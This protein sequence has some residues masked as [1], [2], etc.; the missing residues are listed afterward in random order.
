MKLLTGAWIENSATQAVFSALNVAGHECYFVGGCVRNALLDVHV[1]DI[2]LATTAQPK[3]VV[4]LCQKASLKV[5]PTGIDHGTVTVISQGIAHEVTSFRRDVDTDG[6][7]AVVAFS[8][9]MVEDARR[10]D[11]TMNALYASSQG[12]LID[13]LNGLSDLQA[14]RI[15][16]I[17]DASHRIQEDYLRILRFFRFCAIYGDPVVGFD[18]E[19]LAA[20]AA[21]LDG[22]AKLSRERVGS[23]V[24]KLLAAN[25]PAPALA[26]MRTTGVLLAILPLAD[27]RALA[28]LVHL[29]A[30]Q[31]LPPNSIRRLAALFPHD[32]RAALR[33]S[34]KKARLHYDLVA[35]LGTM[36]GPAA[37]AYHG[38]AAWALDVVL[39]R[40]A[41]FEKTLDSASHAQIARGAIAVCPVK[42]T[43]LMP[44]VQ[45]SALGRALKDCEAR[46][47]ASDFQMT[48][49]ALLTGVK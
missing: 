39:L 1:A 6:R 16:F 44:F 28:P 13:P 23:E 11:F 17:E 27:D 29:E 20:I 41:L 37:L 24:I 49:D 7:R 15:R 45:G 25:D 18:A 2:D 43:D 26:T 48:R 8:D 33:L 47:I 35:A 22:L 34:K 14:R 46:W 21:N 42:S 36:Q 4:A 19:T 31:N 3:T 12:K 10:R 32:A 5:I 40:A 30:A 9:D 38:G